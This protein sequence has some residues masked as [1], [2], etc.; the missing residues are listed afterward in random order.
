[1]IK[2]RIKVLRSSTSSEGGQY[3]LYWMHTAVRTSENPA[4][5]VALAEAASRK[6]PLVVASFLLGCHT[7]PTH[8]RYKFLL[9]GL[10][11][12]QLSLQAMVRLQ[13]RFTSLLVL[14]WRRS[15]EPANHSAE[16][17]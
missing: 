5:D 12:V 10:K 11:D 9:E 16:K 3:V 14:Q 1:L 2:E 4:L 17:L 6:L 13:F 8:R 15:Y 7:Y